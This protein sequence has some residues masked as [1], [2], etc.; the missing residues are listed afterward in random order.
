MAN[1]VMEVRSVSAHRQGDSVV[2]EVSG[3]SANSRDE[4]Y[5]DAAVA[6][7]RADVYAR[8]RPDEGFGIQMTGPFSAR[9]SINGA[10]R[11]TSVRVHARNGVKTVPVQS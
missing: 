1:L 11:V 7:D 5:L 9:T 10:S 6:G 3:E 4:V 8:V 2:V